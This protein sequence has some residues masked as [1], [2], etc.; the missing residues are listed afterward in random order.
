MFNQKFNLNDTIFAS[1]LVFQKT[2]L[3]SLT[4]FTLTLPRLERTQFV[5]DIGMKTC[6]AGLD[7]ALIEQQYRNQKKVFSLETVGDQILRLKAHVNFQRQDPLNL[8]FSSEQTLEEIDAVQWG[9]LDSITELN[10]GLTEEMIIE[11][12]KSNVKMADQIFAQLSSGEISSDET[13]L[14]A[15]GATHLTGEKSVLSF[16]KEKG[17]QLTQILY[18]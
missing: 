1:F 13:S 12:N 11:Y 16:L 7:I 17:V 14:F 3:A 6:G 2:R 8:L 4:T 5:E 18:I 9:N 10:K 15:I